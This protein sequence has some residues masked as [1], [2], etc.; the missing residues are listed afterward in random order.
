MSDTLG[1]TFIPHEA[2]CEFN[3]SHQETSISIVYSHS[4]FIA[5]IDTD[6]FIP[7]FS[8]TLVS[9]LQTLVL[10]GSCHKYP[11]TG[12]VVHSY[13]KFHSQ[14]IHIHQILIQIHQCYH[15]LRIHSCQILIQT[16]Q[17]R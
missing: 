10:L 2:L 12:L 5:L 13:Q 11:V 16:H 14:M 4:M 8:C 3:F 7:C 17:I 1:S 9:L 6:F 15:S